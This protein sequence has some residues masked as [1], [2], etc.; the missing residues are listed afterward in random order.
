MDQQEAW[1]ESGKQIGKSF[2]CQK[3][4]ETLWQSVAIQKHQNTYYAYLYEVPAT[5]KM[6]D[7]E[8]V[9]ETLRLFS[10]LPE[11]ISFLNEI[12]PLPFTDFAPF[13]GN[14]VFSL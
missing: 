11:A 10:N 13:K 3:N 9:K 8:T 6:P 7:P 1:I 12:S 2:F 5:N 4:G 14:Q